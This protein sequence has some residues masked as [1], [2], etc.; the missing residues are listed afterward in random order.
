MQCPTT[1]I[2]LEMVEQQSIVKMRRQII[3]CS[4]LFEECNQNASLVVD[5]GLVKIASE[6]RGSE[7]DRPAKKPRLDSIFKTKPPQP[8]PPLGFVS[9]QAHT[10]CVFGAGIKEVDGLYKREGRSEDGNFRFTRSGPF[11]GENAEF[12]IRK[13]KKTG[14]TWCISVQKGGSSNYLH[15]YYIK[16]ANDDE[17]LPPSGWCLTCSAGGGEHPAPMLTFGR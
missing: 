15:P 13:S 4:G 10:I 9:F 16:S 2:L 5:I 17:S 7:S 3:D 6:D 1:T 8:K 12:L 11:E 14:S